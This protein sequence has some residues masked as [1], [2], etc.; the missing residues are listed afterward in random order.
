MKISIDK[1]FTTLAQL[2]R[3]KEKAKEFKAANTDGDI[4]REFEDQTDYNVFGDILKCDVTVF[5]V[6]IIGEEVNYQVDMIIDGYIDFKRIH[7]Y[8]D[9]NLR[10]MNDSSLRYTMFTE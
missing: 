5:P 9:E 2:P 8:M 4:R 7:F 6:S 10:V 3:V 1:N